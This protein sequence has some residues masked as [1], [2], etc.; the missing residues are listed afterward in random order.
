MTDL[1]FVNDRTSDVADVRDNK[2]LVFV[3]DWSELD[4]AVSDLASHLG[5]PEDECI[6]DRD[7]I[8]V[9]KDYVP[10]L[11]TQYAKLVE[12]SFALTEGW[13]QYVTLQGP[14]GLYVPDNR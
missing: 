4:A 11:L 10:R 2:D 6:I 7:S 8:K 5:C 14:S 12:L 13:E 1:E 3:N 9:I